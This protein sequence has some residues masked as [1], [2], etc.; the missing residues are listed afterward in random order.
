MSI[1]VTKSS[2]FYH[3]MMTKVKVI[4]FRLKGKVVGQGH[5]MKTVLITIFSKLLGKDIKG[6]GRR[7]Q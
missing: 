6:Q 4:R 1:S 5:N 7:S 3:T 2:C